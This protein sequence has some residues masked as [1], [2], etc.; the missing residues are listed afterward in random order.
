MGFHKK[1]LSEKA[2]FIVTMTG[3]A[4]ICQA[5]SDFGKHPFF[6]TAHWHHL[7]LAETLFKA[8]GAVH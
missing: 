7:S 6:N 4:L 2:Y 8:K 3:L 5:S 1:K